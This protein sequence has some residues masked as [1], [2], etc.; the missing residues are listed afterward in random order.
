MS[1]TA[2]RELL[3]SR[4][5][6]APCDLVFEAWTKSE[7]LDRWMG[8]TG[9]TTTTHSFDFRVG[10]EWR[11]TMQH[12]EYGSFPNRVRYVEIEPG[13]R[14]VYDHDTGE[15][16]GPAPFRVTVT[17]TEVGEYTELTMRHLLATVEE[18]EA[19]RRIGAEAF[20]QQTL[21]KLGAVLD[22]H[23]AN[24]LVIVR[25]LAAPV[26]RVWQ[27]WTTP[28]A[29]GAWWGPKGLGLRVERHD[30]RVGGLFH[31][32]MLPP[33]GAAPMWGRMHYRRIEPELRLEWINSFADAAGEIIRPPI[34]PKFPLEIYN[35]L[36]FEAVGTGTRITLR[37]RPIRATAEEHAFFSGMHASM[38]GGFGGTFVQLAEWLAG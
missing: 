3:V 16:N 18:A 34:A 27:A 14:I 25:E 32:A 31:Y 9:F 11:Y 36:T 23:G 10:G 17:F 30:L 20:G 21:G 5:F 4:R 2:D 28:E 35:R 26:A 7:S 24:D 38:E 19:K 33:G 1:N 13:S 6:H 37:G 8:P 15:E 22:E 29:L 12:A